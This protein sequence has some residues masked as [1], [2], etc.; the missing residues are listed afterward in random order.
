MRPERR[1][2]PGDAA[3]SCGVRLL[4]AVLVLLGGCSSGHDRPNVLVITVDTLRADRLGCYGFGLAHTPAIDRLADEGVRCADA[5]TSAPITLPA[6]SSIMTGLYPPAHGVRD[7][8]NYALAPEAVTLAER[9]HDAGY[10]TAAFVS[11]LVLARRYGLD[12]GFDL[13]DDDLWSE[14][15]PPLFMIRKRP[16]PRTA[17]RAL[18]WLRGWKADRGGQ[19]FF[20]WVHFFDPHEPYELRSTDLAALAPTPYDAEVAQADR[21]VGRV[22]D[23][24]R[25]EGVL[26]HT[27]VVFTADHGES[28]GEHGEPTHGIF[29]YDATVHVP[30]IWRLPRV[31]PAGTTYPG[32]VRHVDIVPTVLAV[33]GLPGGD[34][35][36]GANLLPALEGRVAPLDLPQYSEARL[37]EEGF[38]MAPLSG[39]RHAGRK[40]IRAPRP[41]LYDLHDDPRELENLYPSAPAGARPLQVDEDLVLAD[42]ARHTITARPREIDHETEEMLRALGYVAAP[43][44]RAGMAGRDPKDGMVL[45]AEL[46]KARQLA[47]DGRW[48]SAEKMLMKLVAA[49]PENV[50]AHNVLALAA[51]RRG[52]FAEGERQYEGSLRYRPRQHRVLVALGAIALHRGDVEEAE[53]RFHDALDLAPTYVEAMSNLGFVAMVR[54]DATGAQGW[55]ERA[56]A[57]DPSYPH[58]Y[59]RLADLYYDRH[60]WTRAL[61]YYGRVLAVLPQHFEALV[62]AGN[63]ARFQGDTETAARFYA[64]A[65]DTRPDSWIPPYN[66][67]CLRA[68][69]GDPEQAMRLLDRV[70]HLG[71]TAP[72]LL[73]Q[74]EDF[75]SVRARPWWPELVARA[76]AAAAAA[77]RRSAPAAATGR[78]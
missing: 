32:P 65:S 14:D 52:D 3:T 54:G 31:L 16:A 5:A 69:S 25:S 41:E 73:D 36:Q 47:Q 4:A 42:S 2:E 70:I 45:Y 1:R 29:I 58:V 10:R 27:L 60:E 22:L 35:M 26:D 39:V 11:A 19:P 51:V 66:L 30:L 6:H 57:V 50:A 20:M 71:F 78:G 74:N 18:A 62:Q 40:W 67:A 7:N 53:R 13:Y 43:E 37:A 64:K 72:Q 8:G 38:G 61:E 63:C 46:Q 33:L 34:A 76:R 9:L 55:Y 23:W 12:Q 21:G 17:D 77:P 75:A 56:I 28:L 44:E 15:E 48:D 68:I 59:R 24:L 49:A